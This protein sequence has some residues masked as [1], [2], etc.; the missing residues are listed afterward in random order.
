MATAAL[1]LPA[2]GACTG[3]S[4]SVSSED[5]AVPYDYTEFRAAMDGKNFPVAIVGTP[6][7]GLPPEEVSRRLLPAMQA[8]KP[9]PRLTF[10]LGQHAS[11]RLALVFDP[12]TDVTAAAAC[13][14]EARVGPHVAGK[15]E[16]FAVYCRNDMPMSQ[17]VGRTTAIGLDDPALGRLFRDVFQT[18]FADGQISQPNPGYPGGL[19]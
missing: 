11:Y 14:G 18:V 15:V 6:F 8:N 10:T 13:R 9:R 19:R 5:Y 7:V 16:L 3:S 2:L 1:M 12:A 4:V 17:A